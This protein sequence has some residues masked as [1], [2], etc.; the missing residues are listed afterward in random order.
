MGNA[1]DEVKRDAR[2]VV[3]SNNDSGLADAVEEAIFSGKYFM[4]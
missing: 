1:P 3:G 4:E 2:L